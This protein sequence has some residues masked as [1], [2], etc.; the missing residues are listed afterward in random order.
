MAS[1]TITLSSDKAWA[2]YIEWTSTSSDAGYSVTAK[3]YTYKTDGLPT[4]SAYGN[5]TGSFT[6]G[7]STESVSYAQEETSAT[8]R[9]TKTVTVSGD[10][11]AISASIGGP[12]ETT[13]DGHYLSG[14]ET[15]TVTN[16]GGGD[17]GGDSGDS[18]GDSGETE[19]QYE[20]TLNYI[21]G[22]HCTIEE[23]KYGILLNTVTE[24]KSVKRKTDSLEPR[25]FVFTADDGYKLSGCSIDGVACDGEGTLTPRN[26]GEYTIIASAIPM[27]ASG[28]FIDNGAGHSLYEC[29]IDTEYAEY[30]TNDVSCT[31]VGQR[32]GYRSTSGNMSWSESASSY[33][34]TYSASWSAGYDSS[35]S[36]YNVYFLKFTT[37]EFSNTSKELKVEIK[38]QNNSYYS[39]SDPTVRYALCTSDENYS[40]YLDTLDAVNDPYQI[41]TGTFQE[42]NGDGEISTILIETDELKS[43]T[44]YYLLIWDAHRDNII[45]TSTTAMPASNHTITLTC[46]DRSSPT[47]YTK[48]VKYIPYI[49]NGTSWESL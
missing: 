41:A 29:Y 14:S 49:D 12:P 22:E 19:Y 4:S 17:S 6:V 44:T 23:Y 24:S 35:G 9:F 7:V 25:T 18:G 2:G 34:T 31:V 13:L 8:L 15:V 46:E 47:Y 10:T 39:E 45:A 1:G 27:N 5:F 40:L 33:N 21:V 48:F 42:V 30:P 43:N 20:Y 36:R 38:M 11:C 28:I 26:N 37:P 3:L 32:S 16:S